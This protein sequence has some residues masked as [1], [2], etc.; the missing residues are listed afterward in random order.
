MGRRDIEVAEATEVRGNDAVA[1]GGKRHNLVAPGV[2]EL[3][4]AMEE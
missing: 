1:S 4:V 2:P 3:V